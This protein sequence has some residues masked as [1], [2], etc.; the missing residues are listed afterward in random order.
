MGEV[1]GGNLICLES[2]G[3]GWA[4]EMSGIGSDAMG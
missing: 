1:G 3:D 4:S 2:F